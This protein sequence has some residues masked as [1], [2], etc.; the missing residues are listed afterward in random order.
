MYGEPHFSVENVSVTRH[1]KRHLSDI[2]FS[3]PCGSWVS[4]IGQ[5]GAGK[6]TLLQAIVGIESHTGVVSLGEKRLDLLSQKNRAAHAAY[7]PQRLE[8]SA[9]F[10]VE[11]FIRFALYARDLS[12]KDGLL[13]PV[14]ELFRLQGFRKRSIQELSVGEFQRVSL[15]A[16]VAQQSELLLLDEP[17][18]A[19]DPYEEMQAVSCMRAVKEREKRTIFFVSHNL[20]HALTYA[21]TVIALKE[22]IIR[23]CG[24]PQQL[25]AQEI[26]SELFSCSF[27]VERRNESWLVFAETV[28]ARLA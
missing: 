14:Y 13:E 8:A 6:S 28:E 17:S 24:S 25:I 18:S 2:S 26:L 15:A 22:G 12:D 9:P 1:G 27:T 11:E 23:F 7:V 19:L 10:S 16:A 21:D 20:S 4:I 3:V 5:N